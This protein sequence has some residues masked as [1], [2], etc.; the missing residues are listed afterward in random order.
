M[1]ELDVEPTLDDEDCVAIE[2]DGQEGS[3]EDIGCGETH[4]SICEQI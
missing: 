2:T 4:Y 1:K 3:W